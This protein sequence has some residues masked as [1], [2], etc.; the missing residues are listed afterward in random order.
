MSLEYQDKVFH[1]KIRG[2]EM[3]E[4]KESKPLKQEDWSAVFKEIKKKQLDFQ[5]NKRIIELERK[6]Y[7]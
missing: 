3:K 1:A 7:G 5:R 6:R 4:E 2:Y